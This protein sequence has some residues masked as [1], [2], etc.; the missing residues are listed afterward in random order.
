[1]QKVQTVQ[2]RLQYHLTA[3]RAQVAVMAMAHTDKK[4]AADFK[5]AHFAATEHLSRAFGEVSTS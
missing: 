5:A 1:M 3:I 2:D 4:H